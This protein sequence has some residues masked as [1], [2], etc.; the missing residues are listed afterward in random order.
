[1]KEERLF[2]NKLGR[3]RDVREGPDGNLYIATDASDGEIIRLEPE[4]SL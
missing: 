2:E 1:V 3:I 4:K